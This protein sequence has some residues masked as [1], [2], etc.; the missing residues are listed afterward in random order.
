MKL[1]EDFR[2]TGLTM[3]RPESGV[4][5]IGPFATPLTWFGTG[6]EHLLV[7]ASPLLTSYEPDELV[8]P[9]TGERR[10]YIVPEPE[11]K[12]TPM[13]AIVDVV[14]QRLN[15]L[16][17]LPEGWNGA[18]A[19]EV[20]DGAV[21]RA[22]ILAF[23]VLDDLPLSPQFFPLPNGGVQFEWH[24]GGS[25]VEIEVEPDGEAFAVAETSDGGPAIEE[26]VAEDTPARLRAFLRDMIRR[27]S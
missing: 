8:F 5:Q 25:S 10:I 23:E 26:D 17:G 24:V 18:N 2:P 4:L 1:G 3:L 9:S 22:A 11:F 20:A 6:E 7:R 16:L 27:A 13:A 21:E 12:G 14:E 15:R 19:S